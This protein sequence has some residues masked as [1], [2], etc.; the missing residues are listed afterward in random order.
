MNLSTRWQRFGL[1]VL[2]MTAFI[3]TATADQAPEFTVPGRDQTVSI[4]SFRGKV[5]YL[6][7]WASWCG[8]CRKSFPWMNSMQQR[9]GDRGL[10]VLAINLDKDRAL[11]DKFLKEV[12]AQ[13]A[14]GYDPEGKVASAYKVKG[15]PSSYLIDSDGRI[16]SRHIGFRDENTRELEAAIQTLLTRNTSNKP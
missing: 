12:P 4:Q 5:V 10:V 16:H 13:F 7:F 11:S 8:P 3:A 2:L 9:Y 6:D 1:T 15:M 14:I